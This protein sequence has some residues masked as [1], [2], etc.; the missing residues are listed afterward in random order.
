MGNKLFKNSFIL[1]VLFFAIFQ[2]NVQTDGIHE[3]LNE[4]AIVDQKIMMPIRD[5]I[6]LATDIYRPKTDKTVPIIFSRTTYNF[7]E[8]ENSV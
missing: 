3:K 7:N 5:G 6:R 8:L 1:G 2:L 4:I